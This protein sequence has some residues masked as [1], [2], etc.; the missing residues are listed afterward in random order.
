MR[1]ATRLSASSFRIP[2]YEKFSFLNRT[3][4]IAIFDFLSTRLSSL[5][6]FRFEPVFVVAIGDLEI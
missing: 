3:T 1:K 6:T 2:I 5:P 4:F